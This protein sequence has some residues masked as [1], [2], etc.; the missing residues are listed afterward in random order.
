MAVNPIVEAEDAPEDRSEKGDARLLGYCMQRVTEGERY[1]DQNYAEKW[2]E[3]YRLWRGVWAREDQQRSSERS[4]LISPALQSAVESTVAEQEEAVFGRNQ[5]FDLVDDYQDRLSGQDKDL[6]V[7]RM[8]LMDRFE[9]ANVPSAMSEIFLN[10]ALY[11]TGIGKIITETKNAKEVERSVDQQIIQQIQQAAQQGQIAPEQAQQLA[12]QAVTYDVVDKDRFLVK[13]ESVSPF[14]FVID[15]AA[16]NIE[17]AEFCAHVTYKPLHQIIE[18]QMEGIYN[19]VDVGE[20]TTEDRTTGEEYDDTDA[21]KLTEYFGLVPESLLDVD[22]EENE[23]LVDL[24]V[25][26][27]QGDDEDN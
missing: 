5:W 22:L 2:E 11:G 7:L 26:R 17:E 13:I 3:Y 19:P 16:R 18:K 25:D 8:F 15:P 12:Q 10:A 1:R 24:N 21:V 4:K 23:E 9:E 14:D 20:V 27:A 6:Q